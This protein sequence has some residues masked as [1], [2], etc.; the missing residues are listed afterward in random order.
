MLRCLWYVSLRFSEVHF[1]L[2]SVHYVRHDEFESGSRPQSS[3]TFPQNFFL[4]PDQVERE[5]SHLYAKTL[6]ILSCLRY[7]IIFIIM[8]IIIFI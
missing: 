5:C 7:I 8:I 3:D 4:N 2:N 6:W 1:W